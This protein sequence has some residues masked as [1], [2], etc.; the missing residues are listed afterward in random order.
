MNWQH[1]VGGGIVLAVFGA[2][3]GELLHTPSPQEQNAARVEADVSS[4]AGRIEGTSGYIQQLKDAA[5]AQDDVAERLAHALTTGDAAAVEPILYGHD[6]SPGYKERLS[7][8]LG[9]VD[10][11]DRDLNSEA[12]RL[13]QPNL[14]TYHRYR[15]ILTY[16][17]QHNYDCLKALGDRYRSGDAPVTAIACPESGAVWYALNDRLNLLDEC[18]TA[19]DHYLDNVAQE[20]QA[21]AAAQE[22]AAAPYAV[23]VVWRRAISAFGAAVGS[24]VAPG[25]DWTSADKELHENCVEDQYARSTVPPPN[26]ASVSVALPQSPKPNSGASGDT[27][28]T[29]GPLQPLDSTNSPIGSHDSDISQITP[30]SDR[31]LRNSVVKALENGGTYMWHDGEMHG[32]TSASTPQNDANGN[33]CRNYYYTV[34]HDAMKRQATTVLSCKVGGSWT[35]VSD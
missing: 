5:K 8:Y 17:A 4:F 34:E 10:A 15:R 35:H 3:V 29:T 7:A 13:N 33:V 12:V 20:L 26:T 28:N 2:F 31:V 22:N 1:G 16:Y 18:E 30:G 25:L 32:Y 14:A 23:R 6:A 21:E 11:I 9:V 19:T 27:T 24:N